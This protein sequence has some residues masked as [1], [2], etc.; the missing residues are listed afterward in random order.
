[1]MRQEVRFWLLHVFFL[2]FIL[3]LIHRIIFI[4]SGF[5][6]QT[7]SYVVYPFIKVQTNIA[8]SIQQKADNKKTK[9]E[10]QAEI[11]QLLIERSL[12]R[13]R[14]GQLEAQ[15]V[16][17]E[18]SQ[19]V[20]DFA[21]RYD[22]AAKTLSTVLF[23]Y[24]SPKEDVMFIDGGMN[25]GFAKDDV[26]ICQNSLVGRIIEIYPWYS[27]VAVVTD[28]RCRVSAMVG[29]DTYGVV[30]GKNNGGL[31]LSFVPHYQKVEVGDIV[32]S[33]GQ[34]LMYP[35]GFVLGIVQDVLTDLV[36]HQ[37]NVKPYLDMDQVRHVYVFKKS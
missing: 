31:E 9:E 12:L 3:F 7:I 13:A 11:D 26:V 37:I 1:M 4:S 17:L 36:S 18:Q 6:E 28:Q 30:C 32:I 25:K 34:G 5:W 2:F 10:L 15:Q 22:H 21:Q 35:Q 20:V 29:R 33:T 14:L 19:E 8:Q 24:R 27:K 23:Y 16:M